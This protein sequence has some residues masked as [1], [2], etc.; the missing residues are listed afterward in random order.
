M[1]FNV[2]FINFFSID[3]LSGDFHVDLVCKILYNKRILIETEIFGSCSHEC[4]FITNDFSVKSINYRI[5]LFEETIDSTD[6]L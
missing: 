5:G 4:L 2:I 1:S 3:F 6:L